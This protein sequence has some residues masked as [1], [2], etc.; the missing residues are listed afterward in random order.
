MEAIRKY[1][2]ASSLMSVMTLPETFRNRKLEV[3]VFPADEQE[4]VMKKEYVDRN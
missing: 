3:L 1:I 2:N 4:S